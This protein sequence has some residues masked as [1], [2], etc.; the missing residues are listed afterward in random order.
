M[1][2]IAVQ[3]AFVAVLSLTFLMPVTP[4]KPGAANVSDDPEP[5][6]KDVSAIRSRL[7]A[8]FAKGK[9]AQADSY[10]A[11][12]DVD[13]S[14][15]DIDY[16]STDRLVW[17]PINH[18]NRIEQ[19]SIAFGNP[20]SAKFC[21]PAM[22]DGISRGLAYWF[23]KRPTSTNWW[24]NQIGQQLA[25]EQILILAGDS[26]PSMQVRAGATYLHGPAEATGQQK[27]DGQN[28]VWFAGEQLVR[29]VLTGSSHDIGSAALAI[30][31]TISANAEDGSIQP[32]FSF[33][34]H[35]DL[36]YNGGYGKG[37]LVDSV[38]FASDLRGTQFAFPQAKLDILSDFLLQG[39][40]LM[41]R[42]H[43]LDYGAIGRE[44]SRKEGGTEADGFTGACDELAE[45]EPDNARDFEDLKA[46]IQDTGLPYSYIG[47]KHFWNSDFSVHQRKTYYTSVKMNSRRTNG[48]ESINGENLKGYWLPFGVT[49]I[50][51]R[52]DEY[53]GIFPVWDWTH[54]PG[55]TSPAA[56]MQLQA[57][58]R[59]PGSFVGGVSD[60]EYGASAMDLELP[61]IQAHKAWFYFDDEFVALGAGITSDRPEAV[62]TTLNQ[63]LLKGPV[64]SDGRSVPNGHQLL[65]SVTW[66]LHDGVGYVVSPGTMLNVNIGDQQGSW[67]DINLG[68]PKDSTSAKVFSIW[69]GHGA[70][71]ANGS[72]EY[73]VVPGVDEPRISQYAKDPPVRVIANSKDVQAVRHDGLNITQAVFYSPAHLIL[74]PEL[75]ITVDK[76]CI[77]QIRE[78]AGELEIAASSP[79]G[80]V[81][82]HLKIEMVP[83]SKDVLFDLPGGALSGESLVQDVSL[84]P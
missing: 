82:L 20:N 76:P 80:P 7:V 71:P 49:Y 10:L 8:R 64:V 46:H 19:M 67:G 47:H 84:K 15:R 77:V 22:L 1:N 13:G 51:R 17:P 2:L 26:L 28:L 56:Q 30:K 78:S 4:L 57:E 25:L 9:F 35:G 50:A 59:Q 53:A 12:E 79:I 21:S 65:N 38:Y 52:G 83:G 41:V 61:S 36:L 60:G 81:K 16:K 43:M 74:S 5:V 55:V 42:G 45:L 33:H 31:D 72:Y 58:D 68:Y 40:R 11:S 70:R 6:S 37:F 3:V 32:D 75:G 63:S 14:W 18:L 39:S 66:V 48:T 34:Q 54:L 69:I 44:I 23:E 73:I 29:G 62:S 27:P 24:F